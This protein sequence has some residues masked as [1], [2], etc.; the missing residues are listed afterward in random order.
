MTILVSS[1]VRKVLFRGFPQ[2][3]SIKTRFKSERSMWVARKVRLTSPFVCDLISGKTEKKVQT[4][5]R[6]KMAEIFQ[7]LVPTNTHIHSRTAA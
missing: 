7:R 5:E 1:Y 2:F 6:R 3:K 4:Q